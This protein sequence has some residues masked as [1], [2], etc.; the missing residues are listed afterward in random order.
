M[1]EMVAVYSDFVRLSIQVIV[2]TPMDPS[3]ATTIALF[4]DPL[5]SYYPQTLGSVSSQ[6]FELR[7]IDTYRRVVDAG[8]P[9]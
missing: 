3:E 2:I 1:A 8:H 7:A 6:S 5:H 9:Y 4:V